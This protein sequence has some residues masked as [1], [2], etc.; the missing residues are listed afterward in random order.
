[1]G[2]FDSATAKDSSRVSPFCADIFKE[3]DNKTMAVIIIPQGFFTK[4]KFIIILFDN[5]KDNR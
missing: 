3:H 4:N 2:L 1:V 5:I